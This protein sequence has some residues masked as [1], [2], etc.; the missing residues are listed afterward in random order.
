MNRREIQDAA[1]AWR[2][3][4]FGRFHVLG[5]LGVVPEMGDNDGI[6]PFLNRHRLVLLAIEATLPKVIAVRVNRKG[7][8]PRRNSN[9]A[10]DGAQMNTDEMHFNLYYLRSSV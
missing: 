3:Q 8:K 1:I 2:R 9:L 5:K 10:T 4:P 6:R 7:A